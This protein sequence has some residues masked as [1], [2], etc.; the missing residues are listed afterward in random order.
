MVSLHCVKMAFSILLIYECKPS[1]A[2]LAPA[3]G[4]VER[5]HAEMLLGRL[6]EYATDY[7]YTAILVPTQG[8]V[9]CRNICVV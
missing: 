8:T 7:C 9:K 4:A 6:L 1:T 3:R 2:F 5:T